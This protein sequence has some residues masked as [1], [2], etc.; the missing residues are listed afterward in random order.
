[1]S[2]PLWMERRGQGRPVVLLHGLADDHTL[3]RYVAGTLPRAETIALDLPG[4]GRSGPFPADGT[5]ADV[6][7]AV[8]ATLDAAGIDRFVL[9]GLSMGGGVAQQLVL[10]APDR[11]D[12]LILVSSSPVFP[13]ATR[14]RFLTRAEQAERE[15]MGAVVETSVARW[16]TP[17]WMA[18][19][20]D[21]VERTTA[22]V[23]RMDPVDFARAS[24]ANVVRDVLDRLPSIR[25]PVLFVGGLEDPADARRAAIQYAAALPDVTIHLLPG[26]SHLIP[27]EAPDRLQPV[28]AAFLADLER[29]SSAASAELPTQAIATES[30]H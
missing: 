11:V 12:A 17:G 1:M 30:V 15:G 8:L 29:R 2:A 5:L 19:H 16:F 24:R 28:I 21:E 13:E 23:V 27:V 18:A 10:D 9:A 6:A 4:H 26:V 14:E 20:P 22:T 3:W 25:Q 7:Q